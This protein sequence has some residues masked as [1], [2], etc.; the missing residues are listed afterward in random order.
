VTDHM[1]RSRQQERRGARAY[2]GVVNSGSGSQRRKN[3]VRSPGFDVEFKSTTKRSYSL[4]LDD[5]KKAANHAV[6]E[7][8]GAVFGID[9]AVDEGT[10]RYVV[11]EEWELLQLLKARDQLCGMCNPCWHVDGT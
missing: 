9:F 6:L 4:K 1:K 3:D 8:R 5:L 10:F 7:H 11:L 2:G